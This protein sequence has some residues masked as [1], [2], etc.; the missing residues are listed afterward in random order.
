MVYGTK[1]MEHLSKIGVIVYIRLPFET[2]EQRLND[3]LGRG[4]ILREGQT[5]K[6]LYE[7]RVPLYEKFAHVT[8]DEAGLG[9]E[10]TVLGIIE[11][12][13]RYLKDRR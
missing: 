13:N 4:V 8:V 5:L 7:E 6:D 2:L 3:I 9:I 12:Y 11:G 1:A 10:Q